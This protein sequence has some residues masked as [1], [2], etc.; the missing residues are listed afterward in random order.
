MLFMEEEKQNR[1]AL[2]GARAM[3]L[4]RIQSLGKLILV[5]LPH[6]A[7]NGVEAHWHTASGGTAWY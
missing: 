4:D 5:T 1:F 3:S 6:T 7:C 2:G